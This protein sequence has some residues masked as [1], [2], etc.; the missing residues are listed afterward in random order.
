V[1]ED[2]FEPAADHRAGHDAEDEERDVVRPERWRW[3]VRAGLRR[4]VADPGREQGGQQDHR[5]QDRLR[6]DSRSPKRTT[7]SK[8]RV[9]MP[10][11]SR[12]G[13]RSKRSRLM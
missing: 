7:G 11:A 3:D 8:A 4:Q 10:A 2:V 12:R 13:A 1:N 5:Q 6:P 9:I